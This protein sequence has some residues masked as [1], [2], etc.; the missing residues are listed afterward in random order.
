MYHQ[1]V[2][3]KG[4]FP[5]DPAWPRWAVAGVRGRHKS[6]R[7]PWR[8]LRP[9]PHLH[10]PVAKPKPGPQG[11]TIF[12][13]KNTRAALYCTALCPASP[14]CNMEKPAHSISLSKSY[15][16]STPRRG[17]TQPSRC[18]R[19]NSCRCGRTL[20]ITIQTPPS[21]K[22][23]HHICTQLLPGATTPAQACCIPPL[24]AEERHAHA[25]GVDP[26][27]PEECYLLISIE[28]WIYLQKADSEILSKILSKIFSN[29]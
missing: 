3:D 25:K 11:G 2:R 9:S 17:W 12:R 10:A 21:G 15:P 14:T 19:K 20:P 23:H 22:L 26:T 29:H 5:H 7:M 13:R 27:T 6:R 16:G 24:R 18:K 1:A 28:I 8:G 4:C